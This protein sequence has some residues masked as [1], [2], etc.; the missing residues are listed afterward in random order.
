MHVCALSLLYTVA[1]LLL[2]HC[3]IPLRYYCF[4]V[5]LPLLEFRLDECAVFV[6]TN[7]IVFW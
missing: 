5:V 1:L 7:V 6:Q 3:F 2:Y 4:T